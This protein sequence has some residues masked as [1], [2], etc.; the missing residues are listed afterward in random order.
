M[1]NNKLLPILLLFITTSMVAKAQSDTTVSTFVNVHQGNGAGL[2]T[3]TVIDTFLF[4]SDLAGYDSIQMNVLLNCPPGGCDPWDRFANVLVWHD[5]NWY[6]IGRYMTPYGRSCGWTLDVSDYR[7]ML[8]DTVIIKSFID[9]WTNPGW[10]VNLDFIFSA[11]T[12][13][14]PNIKVENLWSNYNAVYGDTTQPTVLAQQQRSIE[15]NATQVK[16]KIVNTGHG[17]G[18]T[19]N[20]AEFS[21]KTHQVWVNGTISYSQFLWRTDCA[22]NPCS[23]QS[24][25]WQYNRAGW[26]PGA[27]VIPDEYDITAHVTPG[28]SVTLDYELQSYFNLCSPNNPGCVTGATCPDCNYNYNGHTEPHYKIAGQLISYLSSPVGTEESPQIRFSLSPNP[29]RELF[30]IHL[31]KFHPGMKAE[32]YSMVGLKVA[33]LPIEAQIQEI[34]T[35]FLTDGIYLLHI[36]GTV[37]LPAMKLSIIK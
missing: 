18:N 30:T 4:P 17:Q 33:S 29:A 9:T 32:I 16:V 20:A 3:R 1:K 10:L 31:N 34:E 36:S 13:L 19:N 26:C 5:T 15:P 8:R 7:E 22:T 2:A 11:G 6:E 28:A 14:H 37:G 27:D 23:P 25:T 21:Q 24:G 35:S 12:P